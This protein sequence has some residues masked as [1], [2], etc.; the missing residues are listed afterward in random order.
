MGCKRPIADPGYL[1]AL[2]RPNVNL[3]WDPIV[4]IVPEGVIT[5]SGKLRWETPTKISIQKYT[6]SHQSWHNRTKVWA[7]CLM[8]RYW[9]R[10]GT[11]G[12]SGCTGKGRNHS[13]RL[14]YSRGRSYWIPGYNSPWVSQL[15][16]FVW[17]KY[18]RWDIVTLGTCID[19]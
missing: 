16:Y 8:L 1:S 6:N 13:Q 10:R 14:L 17:T 19:T 7:W 5:K 9:V 18:P 11:F 2:H 12:R 4:R 3:E 15:D